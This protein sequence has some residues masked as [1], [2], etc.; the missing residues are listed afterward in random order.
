M[1]HLH[2]TQAKDANVQTSFLLN[3]LYIALAVLCGSFRERKSG[4]WAFKTAFRWWNEPKKLKIFE[5]LEKSGNFDTY[6]RLEKCQIVC[7]KN[8]MLFKR[9]CGCSVN[10]VEQP[11]VFLKDLARLAHRKNGEKSKNEKV[12]FWVFWMLFL[13]KFK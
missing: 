6:Y 1:V 5:N 9:G 2:L 3:I 12:K 8:L 11:E 10:A 13:T 7:K 4:F